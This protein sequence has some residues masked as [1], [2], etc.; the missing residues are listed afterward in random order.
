[1]QYKAIS[2]RFRPYLHHSSYFYIQTGFSQTSIQCI[3]SLVKP[4]FK[5]YKHRVSKTFSWKCFVAFW[6][7]L[8][9]GSATLAATP[10]SHDAGCRR[11]AAHWKQRCSAGPPSRIW[12]SL[13]TKNWWIDS[14]CGKVTSWEGISNGVDI[15]GLSHLSHPLAMHSLQTRG[16]DAWS[17]NTMR[18]LTAQ[19]QAFPA[20]RRGGQ[21]I[22]GAVV[23]EDSGIFNMWCIL[24]LRGFADKKLGKN[25]SLISFYN[26]A[27]LQKLEPVRGVSESQHA[28]FLSSPQEKW[29]LFGN[30]VS[31]FT[32]MRKAVGHCVN[33]YRLHQTPFHETHFTPDTFYTRQLSQQTTFTPT[34]FYT[35]RILL[36]QPAFTPD[37]FYTNQLLHE[38]PFTPTSFY[39]RHLLHQ[40]PFHETPFTPDTLYTRHLLHEATFYTTHPF[41]PDTFYTRRLL[42]QTPFTSTD[43]YTT[44]FTPNTFYT[45]HLLHYPRQADQGGFEPLTTA[46]RTK[47]A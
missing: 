37:T 5:F 24:F 4:S 30:R 20:P 14:L 44:P 42:H 16:L 32:L 45:K 11:P 22:F 36:H 34:N 27:T 31:S 41:T 43:F 12:E 26:S 21:T 47:I 18:D 10:L 6:A 25:K 38:T 23:K 39:T 13:L 3:T 7:R 46:H 33:A 1:M 40:K 9:P 15:D 17:C 2:E 35:C 19:K 29:Y 8:R 28:S